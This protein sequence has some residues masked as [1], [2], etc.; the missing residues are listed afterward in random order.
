MTKRRGNK[1]GTIY[2]R[3]GK[4][5]AQATLEGHR[6]SYTGNSRAEVQDWLRNL[7][8]QKETGL[9]IRGMRLTLGEFLDDWLII[10]KPRLSNH[11]W[12]T[13]SQL[14]RDYIGPKLGEIKL[15]ELSPSLIQRFYNQIV[16]NGVGLRTSQKTHTLIHASL[17]TAMKQGLIGRNPDSATTPPKPHQKEMRFLNETQAKHLLKVAK[18][19]GDRN[20]A[21]Y[22]LALVTGMRQG[23]LLALRWSEV[24]LEKGQ[25]HVKYNLQRMP[26]GGLNLQQPKTK[27][28][29]RTIKLGAETVKALSNQKSS[30]SREKESAGNLWHETDF[31]FPSAVGTAMDATNLLK[32][33]RRLLRNAK[34][35]VI[36]FHDLRHT[37]A[38][39]MLNN[40]VD[41]LV[42]S[43]RLGHAKPSIT[44]DVYGHLI[45]S[46]QATAA[47]V[48]DNLIAF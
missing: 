36:R 14:V 20:F 7:S 22:Y 32:V 40:G 37:A 35:P 47:E 29:I 8:N 21:L 42:A 16:A 9:T 13:Y 3:N 34:L 15:Q 39:L 1:E 31:V 17:N 6:V 12:R 41:V 26:G 24:D 18:D 23:E 43:S 4:W 38:S 27:T 44:L 46:R 5:R 11:T 30:I 48:M 45:A 10:S 25:L 19:T 2:K 33:F 28:S